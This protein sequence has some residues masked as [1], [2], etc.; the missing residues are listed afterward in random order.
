MISKKNETLES[1]LIIQEVNQGREAS[2]GSKFVVVAR[3]LSGF[4]PATERGS[5]KD[6]R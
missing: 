4:D 2:F 6:G 3:N 5:V 1:S